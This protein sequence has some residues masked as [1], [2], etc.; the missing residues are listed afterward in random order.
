MQPALE[1]ATTATPIDRSTIAL[2]FTLKSHIPA[3]LEVHHLHIQLQAGLAANKSLISGPQPPFTIPPEAS[4]LV[5]T[6]VNLEAEASASTAAQLVTSLCLRYT[7]SSEALA[8]LPVVSIDPSGHVQQTHLHRSA[9]PEHRK[10]PG[11]VVDQALIG[12]DEAA[13]PKGEPLAPIDGHVRVQADGTEAG[14]EGD[15]GGGTACMRQEEG[16]EAGALMGDLKG[17]AA[18]CM[19]THELALDLSSFTA[20]ALLRQTTSGGEHKQGQQLAPA[21][22]FM[23]PSRLASGKDASL[24]W[25]IQWPLHAEEVLGMLLSLPLT[26][27]ISEPPGSTS[28]ICGA[29]SLRVLGA[30]PSREVN[31]AAQ[32]LVY[33]HNCRIITI[34][35]SNTIILS[36]HMILSYHIVHT[37]FVESR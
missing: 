34:R 28:C 8:Q 3:P 36:Y 29:R 9:Q 17:S 4:H 10:V 32:Y 25:R 1:T 37:I 12:Y 33:N 22:T 26:C 23:G 24:M 35:Q 16:A 7:L 20:M 11:L 6:T 15:G 18:A 31:Q 14:A 21:I 5:F 2:Q 30:I 19:Y 27:Y 13:T